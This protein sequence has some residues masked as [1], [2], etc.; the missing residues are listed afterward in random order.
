M[1]RRGY[2]L[3]NVRQM[4]RVRTLEEGS[5]ASGT[6][7]PFP[8]GLPPS[9][10]WREMKFGA[11][12]TSSRP[13]NSRIQER[14]GRICPF[15]SSISRALGCSAPPA[16]GQLPGPASP[17][18]SEPAGGG[19]LHNSFPIS[20]TLPGLPSVSQCLLLHT[21]LQPSLLSPNP[22]PPS[23]ILHLAAP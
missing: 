13:P 4:T 20:C 15:S 9:R 12:L 7:P 19:W 22:P 17:A 1:V 8:L 18:V 21:H 5:P 10:F 14:R 16:A 3:Q 2:A 11:L 6:V 23:A